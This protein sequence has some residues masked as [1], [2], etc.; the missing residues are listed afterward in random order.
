LGWGGVGAAVLGLLADA[1]SI[2]L[3]FRVCSFL[4]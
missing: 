2:N 1:T 3:V 4:L